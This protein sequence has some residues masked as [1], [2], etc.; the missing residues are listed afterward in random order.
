VDR[1]HLAHTNRKQEANLSAMRHTLKALDFQTFWV[2]KISIKKR[3]ALVL[4]ATVSAFIL[5][6]LGWYVTASMRGNLMARWDIAHGHYR[7]LSYGLPLAWRESYDAK[8]RARYGVESHAVA[9]CIVSASLQAYVRGYDDASAD[10]VRSRFG[11]DVLR[12]T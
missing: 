6:P 11:H 12:Q 5:A 9:G 1:K 7:L 10:A 8:L 4:V 3:V 2:M